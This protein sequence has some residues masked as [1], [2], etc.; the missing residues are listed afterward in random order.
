[1]KLTEFRIENYR[2]IRDSGWVKIDDIAAIVGK[3]ES[4]KTSLLKAL[5]KFNPYDESGYN[6]DREWPRGHRTEKSTD[7][8][9]ATCR[10]TFSPDE[11]QKLEKAHETAQGIQSV[12]IRRTYK[13]DYFYTFYPEDPAREHEVSWVID[14]VNARLST[15]PVGFSDHFKAQFSSA[16]AEFVRAAREA[17]ASAYVVENMAEIGRAH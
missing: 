10:F 2:S 12:E 9:V 6:I 15:L 1:M 7:K 17:G 16:L 13:G 14:L 3:N 8:T 5:W 11:I 4:G